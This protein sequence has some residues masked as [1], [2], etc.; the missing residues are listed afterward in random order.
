MGNLET[1][2]LMII[3]ENLTSD[4]KVVFGWTSKVKLTKEE[5][6]VSRT[7][8]PEAGIAPWADLPMIVTLY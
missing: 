4:V 8:T 7:M 3:Q 2:T 6:Q 5:G 1:F